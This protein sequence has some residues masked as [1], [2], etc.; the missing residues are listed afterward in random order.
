MVNVVVLEV[1]SA[2]YSDGRKH[3]NE[4]TATVNGKH[5]CT[6]ETP[7]FTA[8]RKLLADGLASP[9]DVLVMRHVRSGNDAI[10][11]VVDA[12]A[13]FSISEAS[14]RIR[15]IAYKTYGTY[16]CGRGADFVEDLT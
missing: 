6:S 15:R 4:F 12:A 13:R 2:V 14:G 7:L 3:P 1:K 16:G 5:I 11:T 10:R 8:A 9:Q